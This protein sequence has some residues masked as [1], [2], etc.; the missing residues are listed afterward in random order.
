MDL[1]VEDRIRPP[2]SD[3]I[4]LAEV[5]RS[6][7]LTVPSAQIPRSLEIEVEETQ[8]GSALQQSTADPPRSHFIG[9]VDIT[10]MDFGEDG[11]SE[12]LLRTINESIEDGELSDYSAHSADL[13]EWE[14]TSLLCLDLSLRPAPPRRFS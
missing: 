2:R 3:F 5:C 1:E 12:S 13:R 4:V 10:P 8:S 9:M 14:K 6:N 7:P 11:D